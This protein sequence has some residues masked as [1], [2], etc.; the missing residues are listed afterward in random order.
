MKSRLFKIAHSI[1]ANY[2]TFS[3]ALTA[4]WKIIKL[5]MA[6]KLGAVAF[7]FMKVDGTLRKAIGTL[8]DVPASTGVKATNYGQFI[9]W[10]VE[11]AG[12]RSAKVQNLIF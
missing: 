4:A 5:R 12:Y 3:E 1:K 6:M 2:T 9:Y 10:D 8:K 7:S 11:T